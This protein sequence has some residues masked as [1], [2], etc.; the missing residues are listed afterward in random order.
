MKILVTGAAGFIGAATTLR[1]LNQG[2]IV[3]G[4]DNH[5]NYYDKNLKDNVNNWNRAIR[6]AGTIQGKVIYNF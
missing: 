4:I 6:Y 5:N 3:V 2:D 1:L